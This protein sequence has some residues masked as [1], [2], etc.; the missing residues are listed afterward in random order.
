MEKESY[1]KCNLVKRFRNS[2]YAFL[3]PLVLTLVVIVVKLTC[4]KDGE[5]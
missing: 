3:A 5:L 4:K 1:V 2:P